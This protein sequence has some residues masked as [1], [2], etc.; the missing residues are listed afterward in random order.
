[1]QEKLSF[2]LPVEPWPHLPALPV[3]GGFWG[4]G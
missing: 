2:S 3:E 4:T 1:L